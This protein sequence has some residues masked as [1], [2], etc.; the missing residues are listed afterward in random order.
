MSR[1]LP[2]LSTTSFH[3]GCKNKHDCKT[4]KK[5]GLNDTKTRDLEKEEEA[6]EMVLVVEEGDGN[7]QKKKKNVL[8]LMRAVNSLKL[9]INKIF[10][11]KSCKTTK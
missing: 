3:P 4:S 7:P 6:K 1:D 9:L 10:F 5:R 2:N 11:R 8:R